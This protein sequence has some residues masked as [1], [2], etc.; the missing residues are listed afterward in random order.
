MRRN[1]YCTTEDKVG[2]RADGLLCRDGMYK[3]ECKY[4]Q[5][6]PTALFTKVG[7][8]YFASRYFIL[9]FNWEN[10]W[11]NKKYLVLHLIDIIRLTV[12][13]KMPKLKFVISV[14]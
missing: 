5:G 7:S 13:Q 6:K 12:K 10:F 9:H 3:I 11:V 14:R 1:H 4:C 8:S 2:L